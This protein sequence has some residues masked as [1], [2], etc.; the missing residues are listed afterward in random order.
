MSSG[1]SPPFDLSVRACG[2]KVVW[3]KKRSFITRDCHYKV[4][5]HS[6]MKEVVENDG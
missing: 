1:E 4:L 5:I 2:V 3:T 6:L